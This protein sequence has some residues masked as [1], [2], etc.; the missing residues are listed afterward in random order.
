MTPAQLRSF[1]SVARGGSV[2]AASAELVVSQPAVSAAV[3]SLQRDLGIALL[4]R[5]GRGVAVTPAGEVLAD[6]A[7][8]ILGLWEEAR[9][10]ARA[11][12]D[13][14]HGTLR[15]AAVTTA[16]E[17][18]VPG[19]L[20]SFSREHP[21]IEIVLEVGNRRRV[22][23]LLRNHRAD[24]AVGGRPP[25]GTDLDTV[26]VAANELVVVAAAAGGRRRP[27]HVD[28]DTM[29]ACTWLV[30][31]PDSGTRSTTEEL[32]AELGLDPTRL[33]IGSNVA[34]REAVSAG[35]GVALLSRAAVSKELSEGSLEEWLAGPLPLR[36]SWNL[37]VR[38]DR[39]LSPAASLF[40]EHLS[41]PGSGWTACE[42]AA[43]L[44]A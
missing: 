28:V 26:A 22:W 29:A 2:R 12:A 1:V 11:A 17:Q 5:E 39:Q 44:Q 35:L 25:A 10:A 23:E 13:P 6:Y 34:I 19:L 21:G 32:L 4:A 15:L 30:R 36:R 31:E 7:E 14:E 24:V 8:R 42:E 38:R 3:A 20:A 41:R 18:V 27:R 37:V 40:R 33:T 9:R 43:P 16:G